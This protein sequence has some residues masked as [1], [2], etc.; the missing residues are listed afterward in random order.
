[1]RTKTKTFFTLET[2]QRT[3]MRSRRRIAF[4]WCGRC[5][6]NTLMLLPEEAACLRGTTR[7]AI[8]REIEMGDLH[9]EESI[10]GTALV[11]CGPL[12]KQMN[13]KEGK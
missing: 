9:F 5:A 11:C 8:Y 4:G 6:A 12:S 13:Y 2:S 1:M 10:S 3:V 7:R